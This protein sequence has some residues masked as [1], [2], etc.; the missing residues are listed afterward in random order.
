MDTS[1]YI[2]YLIEL[3]K[4]LGGEIIQKEVNDIQEALE[5][6]NIVINCT[7]LGSRKLFND[8]SIY[9][10]RGQ[11]L[12]V[13][14]NGFDK[15]IADNEGPNGLCYIIPRINDIVLG[16]TRQDNDWSLEVN[17]K[18]TE[19]ILRKAANIYPQF[20]NAEVIEVKVGLRPAR[21]EIRLEAEKFGDKT[22]IHNYGHGGS[23]FTLSWGCA[24]DVVGI[25]DKL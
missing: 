7:G 19:D 14:S 21:P 20:K 24:Q 4:N 6:Y 5:D 1:I 16:G 12:R 2:D 9:P 11:V 13:K 17:P 23:G 25:V 15:V 18:D 3:F 22:V 8:N 10:V